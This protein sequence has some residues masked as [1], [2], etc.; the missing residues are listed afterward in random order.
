[1]P[2]VQFTSLKIFAF[3]DHFEIE[4]KFRNKFASYKHIM[5]S[6]QT[7]THAHE[8]VFKNVPDCKPKPN[9]SALTAREHQDRMD[10]FFTHLNM[11]IEMKLTILILLDY[12]QSLYKFNVQIH[13]YI[14]QY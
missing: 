11:N 3:Q 7:H 13:S 1:M 4:E 6:A 8:Q 9:R 14:I 12:M 2:V 10:S 5:F